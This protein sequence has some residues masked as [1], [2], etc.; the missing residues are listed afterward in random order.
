MGES[1]GPILCSSTSNRISIH[2]KKISEKILYKGKWLAVHELTYVSRTGSPIAWETVRRA[3]TNVGVVVV[4]K[5]VPS[6]RFIL[7]KQFRP[8][9][10]GYIISF[11]AG[12]A[13]GDPHHA[14]VELKEETGYVGKFI[15]ASPPI[16]AGAS[17]IDD[18]GQIVYV[19]VDEKDPRNKKPEQHLEPGEDIEV[20]LIDPEKAQDFLW[21]QHNQGNFISAN[22]WYLFV[23]PKLV[24]GTG[25]KVS[26]N[27]K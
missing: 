19:E 10:G 14:L 13:A 25:Q 11:P 2:V 22:L 23:L 16:K 15:S 5:L 7:I 8:A 17:I 4:A 20:L 21:E 12:L 26:K 24:F 9:V 1:Y 6:Q 27:K 3:K 18:S